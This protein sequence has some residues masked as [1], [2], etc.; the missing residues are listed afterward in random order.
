M[1]RLLPALAALALLGSTSASALVIDFNNLAAPGDFVDRG[2]NGAFSNSG[3]TFTAT[4]DTYQYTLDPAYDSS[5]APPDNSDFE[6]FE[7][8]SATWTLSAGAPFSLA[9]F[10]AAAIYDNGANTLTLT[11]HLSGGGTVV[12]VFNL[13]SGNPSAQWATYTLPAGWTNLTSVDFDWAGNNVG[14][15]NVNVTVGAASVAAPVPMLPASALAVLVLALLAAASAA[16][17]KRDRG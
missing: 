12:Q 11:G 10:D 1:K 15:D 3:F 14:L 4:G 8:G 6:T 2:V 13:P 7:G 9:R 5:N 16:L 17:R